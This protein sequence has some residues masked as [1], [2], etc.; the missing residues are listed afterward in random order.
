VKI[1]LCSTCGYVSFSTAP[2]QCPVCGSPADKFDQKDN[3]FTESQEKSPEAAVKH[4][5]VVTVVK[6][7]KLVGGSCVDVLVKIGEVA[8]PMEEKHFIQFIDCYVDDR[9]IARMHLTPQSYAAAVF[10]LKTTG[11]KIRVVEHCNIHGWW[12]T[13]TSF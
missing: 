11:S 8:H 6:E 10:H 13:E 9:F 2:E 12:Q 5:P 1:Y 4:I 3:L 7:C